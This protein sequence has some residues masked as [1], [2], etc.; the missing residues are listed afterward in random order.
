[1][2][3]KLVTTTD[4]NALKGRGIGGGKHSVNTTY[5]PIEEKESIRW[6][7]NVRQSMAHLGEG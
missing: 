3:G 6:L 7:E 5:V 2:A 1:M 4:P